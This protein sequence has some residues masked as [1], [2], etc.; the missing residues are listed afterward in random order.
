MW[1]RQQV[2]K[3]NNTRTWRSD[4]ADVLHNIGEGAMLASTFAAPEIEP[5]VYPTYQMAKG[6][7]Q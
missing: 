1:T 2:E 4:V 3:A 7:I 5:L 6:S